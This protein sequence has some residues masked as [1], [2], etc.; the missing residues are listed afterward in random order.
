MDLGEIDLKGIVTSGQV[1]DL[2]E[3]EDVLLMDGVVPKNDL[4]PRLPADNPLAMA[5]TFLLT[6]LIS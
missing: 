3:L 6:F 5:I 2:A 4:D 1:G